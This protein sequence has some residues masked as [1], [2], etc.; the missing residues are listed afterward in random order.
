MLDWLDLSWPS[1]HL[2]ALTVLLVT[3]D[4]VAVARALTRG[5]GVES[6]LAWILGIVA[7]PGVG[8]VAYLL[9]ANPSIRRTRRRRRVHVERRRGEPGPAGPDL[10]SESPLLA[11][12]VAA[13]GYGA[14]PGNRVRLLVDDEA[15]FQQLEAAIQGARRSVWAEY[16]IVRDDE[17]GRRFLDLLTERARAG[18]DVR[19]LYDA[20]G[21][22]GL[23]ARRLAAIREAG[24]RVEPF[25]PVN[26]LRRRWA[27][28]LRNHRKIVL[29]D[30]E[31]AFT[32]GM[33]VGD[34]Y[35]GR[36]RRRGAWHFR[37]AHL[38]LAGPAVAD[39]ALVFADDWSFAAGDEPALPPAAPPGDGAMVALV[40]SG[41][42]QL[43][44]ASGLVYF[45]GIATAR[46]RCWLTTPY[47]VPDGPTVRALVASALR[48][49]D[50]RVLLPARCDVALAGHAAR[51]FY[52][53]LLQAGVR[54]YE[55]GA[56]MLHAKTLVVD[57]RWAV[58]GSANVDMRS[59]RLNFELGV[60]L[61]DPG[62][63]EELA[64]RF[65]GDQGNAVEIS[66]A[67]LAHLSVAT[68]L[69]RGLARLA[70]PIL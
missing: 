48:G 19:L 39:L 2:P 15:A 37:D 51:S 20:V 26:P 40:P 16:Y 4:L 27:V 36:A 34:E 25:L 24:G 10:R 69:G 41:P 38:S 1:P 8:A 68:R 59:F 30:G 3:L 58:V 33:N 31:T 11:A 17:T 29:V 12:A 57:E 49:V 61:D 9:V 62:V 45:T 70:S 64:L 22:I 44:N 60:A 35:S 52:P 53:E 63:V 65:E 18:V 14:T 66:R 56:A 5:H 43:V 67:A 21:S 28:H 50:V 42:D 23:D 47:F 32:G 7:F 13:T 6:T 55:Y 46:R 54:I